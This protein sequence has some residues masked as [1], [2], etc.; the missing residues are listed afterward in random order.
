VEEAND[1]GDPGR[2]MLWATAVVM[3]D[4]SNRYAKQLLAHLGHKVHVEPLPGRPAPAGRL[5]FS[6]GTG[7]VVP[8]DGRLVLEASAEDTES[9]LHVEDV[10]QR[11][12]IKFGARRELV[13]AWDEPVRSDDPDGGPSGHVSPG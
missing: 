12:L 1:G 6:Y 9:L 5:V 8:L 10:L 13:V 11:H 3:T 2:G 7:T 4:A